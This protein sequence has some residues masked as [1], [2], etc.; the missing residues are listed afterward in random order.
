M[1]LSRQQI[2]IRLKNSKS[3]ADLRHCVISHED[4]LEAVHD[5]IICVS[6][7]RFGSANE[8][9]RGECRDFYLVAVDMWLKRP[10]NSFGREARNVANILHAGAKLKVDS[11]H[12]LIQRLYDESLKMCSRFNAQEAANTFWAAATMSVDDPR[13]VS[14]LTRACVDLVK[15]F[16]GHDAANT[17][18][19]A[20]KLSISDTNDINSLTQA[21]IK[22]ASQFNSHEASN[23]I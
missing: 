7:G 5:S 16:N 23:S 15:D 12:K 2:A 21:C 4:S 20:A 11:H 1:S 17:I 10:E 13:I 14:G 3:F 6:C 9:L 19:A 22:C 8:S 18:W